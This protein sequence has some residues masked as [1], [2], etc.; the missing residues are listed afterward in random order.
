MSIA[1]DNPSFLDMRN[2][3]LLSDL[4]T[5]GGVHQDAIWSVFAKRGMGYFAG[6]LGGDDTTPGADFSMPP[7]GNQTGRISGTVTDSQTGDPIEGA[8][9]TVAFQ[10]SPFVTNPSDTTNSSGNY[11]IGPIP[12]GTYPKVTIS[13]P[14]YDAATQSDEVDG[15]VTLDGSLARDWVALAG[16][17]TVV[18]HTGPNFGGG[19]N[20]KS[21]TDQS[22]STSWVTTADLDAN[23]DATAD[24]PKQVTIQLPQAV[25]IS[26]VAIDPTTSPV[27]GLSS[28]TGAFHIEVSDDGV[29]FVPLADGE[30][31]A[32]DRGH[33]NDVDL[34]GDTTN[35]S[36]IRYWIDAPMVLTDTATYPDG[37]AVDPT[38]FDGCTYEA[39]TEME[40]YGTPAV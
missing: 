9:V 15:Q 11:V 17:A 5:T 6:S 28:S 24:T 8:V 18:D 7:T 40:V 23:G 1:A 25:D 2:A 12:Q 4:A 29:T 13:A 31:V 30:F 39:S 32:A 38:G 33:F 37:C 10:G 16:G 21:L 19:F 34:T 22:L 3:I 35:V 20:F 27:L 26:Q 14:G 36:F